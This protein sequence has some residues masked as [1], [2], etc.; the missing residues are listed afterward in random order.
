MQENYAGPYLEIIALL[1][2]IIISVL[3][4]LTQQN[5]LK[6]VKPENRLMRPGM[7]WLQL[8]PLFGQIWQFR[9]VTRIADSIV[10]QHM[11]FGD[12]SIVGLAD[13]TAAENAGKRPTYSIGIIYCISLLIDMALSALPES[14]KLP[15]IQGPVGLTMMVCWIIYWVRL[16][17]EKRILTRMAI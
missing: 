14:H 15:L 1:V 9:V 11:S 4:I 16:A 13:Y 12:D 17:A 7:V 2:F 6:A 10:K 5:T 3:F 8:I